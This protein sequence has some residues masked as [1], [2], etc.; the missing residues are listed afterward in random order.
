MAHQ[1]VL[2]F[3]FGLVTA[4]VL[5]LA[6][7]GVTLQFGVMNYINFAYGSYIALAGFLAWELNVAAGLNIWIAILVSS[8]G[9]AIV[10]IVIDRLVLRP[11][12][13]RKW[14]QIYMLIVT[15]GLWLILSNGLVAI[16][17]TNPRQ[18]SV[19]SELPLHVGPFLLTAQQLIIIAVAVVALVSVHLLLTRTKLGKAMRA[20]SDDRVLAS[21]CGIDA[22]RVVTVTW[23]VAGFLIGLAGCVLA[24][25][26]AS[27]DYTFGDNYLF[28]VFAA[29]ILGGIGQPYGTMIGALIIGLATELSA[30]VIDSAYKND[31]AFGL[32][33]VMLMIRPQGLIPARGRQ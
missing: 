14:P 28:V 13:N 21:A 4:S 30:V 18:F 27:F 8:I 32:L 10:A 1:A 26:L 20:M 3:G 5:A 17:G 33:I 6:A 23:L 31:V 15:L 11:F 24:L 25:N 9:M 2:A 22:K 12:S 19:A 7:V 29:V 16:W